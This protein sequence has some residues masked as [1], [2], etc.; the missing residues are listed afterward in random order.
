MN[1][2]VLGFN[3]LRTAR[4][5]FFFRAFCP[6]AVLSAVGVFAL[7]L[8]SRAD[9]ASINHGNFMGSTVTYVDVTEAS[10][11]DAVPLYGMP[12]VFGDSLIS[13]PCCSMR[14]RS[15]GCRPW[16]SRMAN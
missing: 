10:A 7:V 16:I 9:A 1:L 2:R 6:C 11:T 14:F 4:S 15:W 13:I 3:R 12:S 8:G 5:R